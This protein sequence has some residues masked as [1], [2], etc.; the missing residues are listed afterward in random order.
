MARTI[1]EIYNNMAVTASSSTVLDT[2]LSGVNDFETLQ[3][4]VSS[5]SK[6]GVLRMILYVTAV[7]VWSLEKIFDTYRQ[8]LDHIAFHTPPQ[9][10][11]WM[12]LETL[13]FQLGHSLEWDNEATK[14]VYTT[15][16]EEKQIVKHA[17]VVSST[18]TISIKVAG[19]N[20][21]SRTKLSDSEV[22]AITSYW[23]YLSAPGSKVQVISE[24]PDF[25]KIQLDVM[26]DPLV[27][28]KTGKLYES[29][30]FPVET[31]INNYLQNLPFN[32]LLWVD[33]LVDEIQKVNGVVAPEVISIKAKFDQ[34]PY[35]EVDKYYLSYAG[36]MTLDS[37]ST[38][39]YIT[40]V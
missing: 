3:A 15:L 33:D 6:V 21:T 29:S 5:R 20:D 35:Q 25:L 11:R 19:G 10:E 24:N 34:A 14:Y 22:S 39:N 28:D 4:Q 30:E 13:K 40:Y 7:A 9:T 38:I 32:S 31:A 12:V 23:E 17:A 26:I 27:M 8:E 37:S 16:D 36:Y 2:D 18:D 1:K